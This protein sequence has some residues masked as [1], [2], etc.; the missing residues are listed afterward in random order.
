MTVV[1]Y[2]V[3]NSGLMSTMDRHESAKRIVDRKMIY[4]TG[5]LKIKSIQLN[6][7][8]VGMAVAQLYDFQILFVSSA[9]KSI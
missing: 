3:R 6:S 4:W 9:Q 7:H 5:I 8:A 1:S 2:T